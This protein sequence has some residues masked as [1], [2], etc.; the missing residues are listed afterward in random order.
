MGRARPGL[1]VTAAAMLAAVST[2]N[3]APGAPAPGPRVHTILVDKM[4][5]GSVPAGMKV[6]DT[7]LWVNR[8]LFRHSASA[9]DRSF[10]VDL[11]PGKRVTTRLTRAG[12]ILFTCKYH[13]GMKGQ[14]EVKR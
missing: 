14:L 8:D 5:F 10:D 3:P 6:G 9:A 11:P 12:A 4:K 7:I 2:A 1:G 13:P